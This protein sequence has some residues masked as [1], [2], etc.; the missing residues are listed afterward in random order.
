MKKSFEFVY[1]LTFDEVYESFLLIGTKWSRK[2]RV[3][4][5]VFLTLIA[6]S[7]LVF[8]YLDSRK[9]HCFFLVILSIL[10]LYYLIYVPVLKAKRGAQKVC[11][12]DGTYK[13]KLTE[14]GSI[15][16]EK[17]VIELAG[18]KDARAIETDTLYV[19]RTDRVHTFCL[20]KRIMKDAQTEAIR[21][22]LKAHIRYQVR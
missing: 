22:I 1:K 11:K 5:G 21:E 4:I 9:I 7:M 8:Y 10:L 17:E 20:P 19:I 18:D 6:V 16:A 14:A 15:V 12:K 3:V 2:T 13:V